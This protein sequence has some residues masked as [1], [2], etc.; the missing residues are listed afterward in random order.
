MFHLEREYKT[1]ITGS[2]LDELEKLNVARDTVLLVHLERSY[3]PF[4]RF[5]T[6]IVMPN[7]PDIIEKSLSDD[8]F[9]TFYSWGMSK[10][11]EKAKMDNDLKVSITTEVI[12]AVQEEC[13]KWKDKILESERKFPHFTLGLTSTV[14]TTIGLVSLHLAEKEMLFTSCI[15]GYYHVLLASVGGAAYFGAAD[16]KLDDQ[17]LAIIGGINLAVTGVVIPWA[18]SSFEE[19]LYDQEMLEAKQ[20]HPVIPV[21]ASIGSLITLIF[22]SIGM[23][24]GGLSDAHDMHKA[25]QM[26]RTA[27]KNLVE[28]SGYSEK[29]KIITVDMLN[30]CGVLTVEPGSGVI[31]E[32]PVALYSSNDFLDYLQRMF[33]VYFND[34][35]NCPYDI[36]ATTTIDHVKFIPKHDANKNIGVNPAAIAHCIN[37]MSEIKN[38]KIDVEIIDDDEPSQ[39]KF[40]KLNK[41]D[42]EAFQICCDYDSNIPR[43]IVK[44]DDPCRTLELR[45]VKKLPISFTDR[46]IQI[47]SSAMNSVR[48]FIRESPILCVLGVVITSSIAAI[49]LALYY[50]PRNYKN[51]TIKWLLQRRKEKLEARTNRQIVLE[52]PKSGCCHTS[53][54]PMKISTDPNKACNTACGGH[55]CTHWAECK[56]TTLEGKGD[57]KTMGQR[58]KKAQRD[59]ADENDKY[60]Q[61]QY[62]KDCR[63]HLFDGEYI[64]KERQKAESEN[65]KFDEKEYEQA[66]GR[67]KAA[68]ANAFI[69]FMK[70]GREYNAA[71]RKAIGDLIDKKNAI[72]EDLNERSTYM[73]APD[74]NTEKG[75]KYLDYINYRK[76]VV[77]DL[78]NNI[79][80]WYDMV[81][82]NP[83]YQANTN[84]SKVSLEAQKEIDL[85]GLDDVESP[86]L[87]PKVLKLKNPECPNVKLN[88]IDCSYCHRP[89][90]QNGSRIS[91]EKY[92]EWATRNK[93]KI[94][95]CCPLS[96]KES[97]PSDN[98]P[99]LEAASRFE[100]VNVEKVGRSLFKMYNPRSVAADKF[101]GTAVLIEHDKNVF[102]LVTDHQFKRDV[103]IHN[104][105]QSFVLDQAINLRRY[106]NG[107]AAFVLI[108]FDEIGFQGVKKTDA[109]KI[110]FGAFSK[111]TLC[112]YDPH[113][114]HDLLIGE[115][116]LQLQGEFYYH[117][118]STH[119]GSCGSAL[120]CDNQ[121]I[122]VHVL[123][124]G[125]SPVGNNNACFVLDS[126]KELRQTR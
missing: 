79:K 54:C 13:L 88:N 102:Y 112:G 80:V 31:F 36:I 70:T 90:F 45:V 116:D 115:S 86:A 111:G 32:T 19:A 104:G 125:K 82:E 35:D 16:M 120:I 83:S 71:K 69:H 12:T 24:G 119:D 53:T 85:K 51:E 96:Y 34:Y 64:N 67:Q 114:N 56:P 49:L 58:M 103:T 60:N 118:V 68:V 94:S 41:D 9:D 55:H 10:F 91:D 26:I 33:T 63:A 75:Q 21:L 52:G 66:V 1:N 11:V 2:F 74:L 5:S 97:R 65:R 23:F 18:V 37:S 50:I 105:K 106:G 57:P 3:N 110:G 40:V 107:N 122:G 121:L 28:Q 95:P 72:K 77:K 109:L 81:E 89:T 59:R 29:P 27:G 46:S 98:S 84:F 43:Y 15:Y 20:E 22:A 44:D 93:K 123:S 42:V 117:S 61:L 30:S 7:K 126:L 76:R 38:A 25:N 108:P 14:G 124:H 92:I 100:P 87:K 48:D 39:I 99:V 78:S 6:V 73:N 8:I 17:T 113:N 47:A 62:E 4:K 101:W